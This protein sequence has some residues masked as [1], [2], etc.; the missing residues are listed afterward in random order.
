MKI[1]SI[2][3]ANLAFAQEFD[4]REICYEEIGCFT[5]ESILWSSSSKL[6][7]CWSYT[8]FFPRPTGRKVQFWPFKIL[9]RWPLF[10]RSCLCLCGEIF[11]KSFWLKNG[12]YYRQGY[13]VSCQVTKFCFFLILAFRFGCGRTFIY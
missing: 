10:R 1:V 13:T 12:T 4:F 11:P 8:C 3:S 6:L 5:N 2:Y 9:L 7:F